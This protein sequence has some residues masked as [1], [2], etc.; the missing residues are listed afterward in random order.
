MKQFLIQFRAEYYCQG[1]EEAI[2]ERLISADTF[3]EAC[4]RIKKINSRD[5]EIGTC[6]DFKNLTL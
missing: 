6:K 3:E 1:Y 2:F 5:W 4:N